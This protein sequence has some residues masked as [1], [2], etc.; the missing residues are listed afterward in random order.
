MFHRNFLIFPID[1]YNPFSTLVI[2]FVMVFLCHLSPLI[3]G[4]ERVTYDL[5][6]IAQQHDLLSTDINCLFQDEQGYLWLGTKAGVSRFDGSEFQH[7]TFTEGRNITEI[8][9]IVQDSSGVIWAGGA[10]GLYYYHQGTFHKASGISDVIESLHLDRE[11]QLLVAGVLF[12]P[13]ALAPKDRELLFQGEI[14]EAHNLVN[15]EEWD[16]HVAYA[17]VWEITGNLNDKI[18]IGLDHQLLE[19]EGGSLKTLWQDFSQ[20]TMISEI[21]AFHSDSIFWGSERTGLLYGSKDNFELFE[22]S[23]TY[24]SHVTDSALYFLS[25]LHLIKFDGKKKELLYDFSGSENMYFKDL[26]LDREGAFWIGIEGDLIKLTPRIFENWSVEDFPLLEA[27]FSIEELSSGEMIIGS[28]KEKI[29]GFDGSSFSVVHQIDVPHN[30]VTESIY[31]D[32]YGAI[33]HGTSMSGIICKEDGRMT[34]YSVEDGLF[35]TEVL[36]FSRMSDGSLWCGGYNGVTQIIRENNGHQFRS[37]SLPRTSVDVP[38]FIDLLQAPDGSFWA[39]SDHGLYTLGARGLVRYILDANQDLPPVSGVTPAVDSIFY[40][41]TQGSGI[42]QLKFNVDNTPAI[43]K[44]FTRADGLMSDVVLNIHQD[45]TGKIWSFYQGGISR[46]STNGDTLRVR[47][48][49]ENDGLSNAPTAKIQL[50][51]TSDG[52]LW[53]VRKTSLTRFSLYSTSNRNIQPLTFIKEVSLMGDDNITA[54]ADGLSGAGLPIDL[55]LPHDRNFVEFEFN[56]TSLTTPDNVF[57]RYKLE[58]LESKWSDWTSTANVQYRGLNPG[59]YSFFVQAA[60]AEGLEGK[61]SEPFRFS[62]TKPM[63]ARWWAWLIYLFITS[64]I[65]YYI[66]TFNIDKK[67]KELET[68]RLRELD[69]VK[70]NLYTNI[71]HEFRTPL[72]LIL[73]QLEEL[74]E[75]ESVVYKKHIM[76]N[77]KSNGRRLLR[78]VN[79]ILDLSKLEGDSFYLDYKQEDLVSLIKYLVNSFSSMA[80]QSH[81][82]LS[83]VCDVESLVMDLDRERLKSVLSN[84]LSNAMKATKEDGRV[85]IKLQNLKI[86]SS[87]LARITIEDDGIGIDSKD[88]PHIFDRYYQVDR[89]SASGTGIGLA[90]VRELVSLMKGEISVDSNNQGTIFSV[91]LPIARQA[92]MPDKEFATGVIEDT[93]NDADKPLLLIVEDNAELANFIA[94]ILSAEYEIIHAQNGQTGINMARERVPDLIISDVMMPDIDGFV[95]CQKLKEDLKTDH[96][97]IILLTAK[98]SQEDKNFGIAQGADAYLVKPFSRSE[99]RIRIRQLIEGRKKLIEKFSRITNAITMGEKSNPQSKFLSEVVKCVHD[100]LTEVTFDSSKLAKHFAMSESQL[101]RKL[102]SITGKSTAI[103]IRSIRLEKARELLV[104]DDVTVAEVA[105]ATGFNDP[106]WFSRAFK[107]E[108]GKAPS[109]MRS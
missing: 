100:H 89:S 20:K 16:D 17:R 74:K 7:F 92:P 106:S 41:C 72:T 67:Q 95:V 53:V 71:T 8:N 5:D 34:N 13:Y 80:Q 94:R 108:F 32:D 45:S 57:Y 47:N 25:A 26:L 3:R 30:S 55:S 103:F 4:Q 15:R 99:L 27:N 46:M 107:K 6:P 29:I 62:I 60:N 96:I 49:T 105:Y 104:H 48:F 86:G 10:K 24:V 19:V 43:S 52:H 59:E 22:E 35:D 65:V 37:F 70:N 87:S 68:R 76:D 11:D 12:V 31:Q 38:V 42:F 102:K 73:G 97:P 14:A 56:S 1:I 36:F 63:Y 69:R 51:E 66:Y 91:E 78:M 40:M 88:L 93:N 85:E 21:V 83:F 2:G 44:V 9:D 18:W 82:E 81:V 61:T 109:Q 77:I 58:G 39:V 79:E 28:S 54:Y 101:Y 50:L 98:A 23:A 84:L 33:W 75:M 90:L 64:L